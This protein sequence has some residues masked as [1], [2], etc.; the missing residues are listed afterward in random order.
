MERDVATIESG[1]LDAF[2][3]TMV[4]HAGAASPRLAERIALERYGLTARA[5]ALT[6]ERDENFRLSTARGDQYVLKIAN[7]AEDA[8]VTDLQIAALLHV[9]RADPTLPCPRV[10]RAR[11]GNAQIQIEDDSG[12]VRTA[13][14]VS[15]LSGK[16]LR[17]STRS[18]A[19]RRACGALGARLAIALRDFEHPASRRALIWDLASFPRL[20][21]LLQD[22]PN[23]AHADFV[24]DFIRHFARD[25]APQLAKVRHQFV[26]YDFNDRNVIV[27]EADE[28]RI[29]GI[30]DFG[31]AKY[32]TL[33]GDVAISAAAQITSLDTMEAEVGDLLR[34]YHEIQPLEPAELEILNSLIAGRVVMG[35]LIPS[36]HRARNPGVDHFPAVDAEH[37]GRRVA[38][39]R[40]LMDTRFTA[41]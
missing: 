4:A 3:A 31:D 28:A 12:V 37:I 8:A 11:N 13:R 24:S 18:P 30:I 16:P 33:I 23:L 10:L 15:Y 5:E 9:E 19:Q 29:T 2:M 17:H 20:A 38:L 27:D 7:A 14:L 35:I 41:P 21:A 32:A 22:L 25:I 40:R 39:A 36:W 1:E 34:G 6:G 26:H